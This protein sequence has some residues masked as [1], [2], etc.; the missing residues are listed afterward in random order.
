MGWVRQ[1]PGPGA[2]QGLLRDPSTESGRKSHLGR[3]L[4]Q[5]GSDPRAVWSL[6]RLLDEGLGAQSRH[7]LIME[8]GLLTRLGWVGCGSRPGP[9]VRPV[10]CPRS[11]TK[12]M[13]GKEDS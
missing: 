9:R 5:Q 4:P 8:T 7:P 2:V 10:P 12:D 3:L 13:T 6:R 11:L 1:L